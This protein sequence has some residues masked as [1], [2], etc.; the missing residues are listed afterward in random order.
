MEG[1]SGI[2]D[3]GLILS[4]LGRKAEAKV[5]DGERKPGREVEEEEEKERRCALAGRNWMTIASLR[6]LTNGAP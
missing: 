4:Y 1:K 5:E 3:S 2:I 6:R